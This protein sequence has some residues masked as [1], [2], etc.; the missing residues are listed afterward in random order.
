ML[1]TTYKDGRA[2]T[3]LLIGEANVRRYF[4]KPTGSIELRLDDLNIRCT[5]DPDFWNG[6]PQIHDPR[7]SVWLEYKAGRRPGGRQPMHVSL[8]PSGA[9]TFVV[10]PA[11]TVREPSAMEIP[12]LPKPV[13]EAFDAREMDALSVA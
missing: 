2:R 5:L 10:R 12:V 13:A 4:R 1:V 8:V 6:R 9:D 7:L 3:G 11:A